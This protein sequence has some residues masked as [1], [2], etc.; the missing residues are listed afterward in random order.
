M[1]QKIKETLP[2]EQEYREKFDTQTFVDLITEKLSK[3]LALQHEAIK[4]VDIKKKNKRSK[5]DATTDSEKLAEFFHVDL[6]AAR[7]PF[8]LIPPISKQQ[9]TNE[10][11][12]PLECV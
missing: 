2:K 4:S 9:I 6:E 10:M 1:N 12:I 8:F 3:N 7:N 5:L 11:G